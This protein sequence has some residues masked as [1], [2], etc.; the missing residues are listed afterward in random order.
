MNKNMKTV[1]K[2]IKQGNNLEMNLPNYFNRLVTLYEEYATLNL[3]M[4][5]YTYYEN[6]LEST[7]VKSKDEKIVL[8]EVNT[9]IKEFVLSDFSGDRMEEGVQR[10]D[11]IRNFITKQM[12]I[13]TSYTDI[14]LVYEY[15]LE[16]IQYRY[17]D[18]I[19]LV[20]DEEFATEIF[21]YIFAVQDNM[22]INDK[23]KEVL[24]E[25]P[26]RMT[27]SKYFDLLRDSISIYKNG[28]RTSL[29]NYLYILETATSLYEV[30]G[31]EATY[32]NLFD[33]KNE[34]ESL[35]YTNLSKEQFEIYA[36]KLKNVTIYMSDRVDFYYGLQEIVNYLYTILLVTPYAYM[37]GGY[38]LEGME[39]NMKYLILPPGQNENICHEIISDIN[40][41]FHGESKDLDDTEEK[42]S[43]LEGIGEKLW[44]EILIL[45]PTLDDISISYEKV[46]NGLML[47]PIYESLKISQNL[48]SN[49]LFI[50]LNQEEND[51]I[52]DDEY[53]K[54]VQDELISKL[55]ELFNKSSK[56]VV[57]GIMACTLNKMPVFFNTS[58]EIINYIKNSLMQCSDKAE[59]M[60][61][62][63]IIK[64][65]CEI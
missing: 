33:A 18:T 14:F 64:D 36:E 10:V 47:S 60:A 1:C 22:I 50:E 19:E 34:F 56:Q 65:L 63:E 39:G 29:D 9:I 13:L 45:E 20:D 32:V 48:L 27:K 30:E 44:D 55:T 52:A 12:Q 62:I 57:R 8:D 7:F 25:L 59:K 23:I 4:N 54:K 6:Y 5:Y 28:D 61:S 3:T 49:S 58:E 35:D 21:N 16:R 43:K 38:R 41:L 51:G 53:I 17:T 37:D 11:K 46:V 24:G 31:M 26:V 42:L 40:N 2:E 15:V